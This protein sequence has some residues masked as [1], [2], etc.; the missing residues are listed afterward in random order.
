MTK[1]SGKRGFRRKR[2]KVEVPRMSTVRTLM[3]T[4]CS[5]TEKELTRVDKQAAPSNAPRPECMRVAKIIIVF[6]VERTVRQ[7]S[8][9]RNDGLRP[10]FSELFLQPR[11][12]LQLST[13]TRVPH[14]EGIRMCS[15]LPWFL[16]STRLQLG[17]RRGFGVFRDE[18]T[19]RCQ[20]QLSEAVFP[21]IIGSRVSMFSQFLTPQWSRCVQSP[22]PALALKPC[23]RCDSGFTGQLFFLDWAQACPSHRSAWQTVFS[24]LSPLQP[25]RKGL[26]KVAWHSP[27]LLCLHHD[28][29]LT[30][31]SK[32]GHLSSVLQ[33][34]LSLFPSLGT[35][36]PSVSQHLFAS[37][38][39]VQST[40]RATK[41]H[42]GRQDRLEVSFSI[43]VQ[44][45][46][47][48]PSHSAWQPMLPVL[49]TAAQPVS[50]GRHH[51]RHMSIFLPVCLSLASFLS[52][53][54]GF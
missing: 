46:F 45:F 39:L 41:V 32:G 3:P 40:A 52:L 1:M 25:S 5:K 18:S 50:E 54:L 26:G 33:V 48:V 31:F 53:L 42:P 17:L 38:P 49:S 4:L 6:C 16:T 21:P 34:C 22:V 27:S 35:V 11:A 7:S 19:A 2:G 13:L 44:L 51:E 47:F 29:G 12:Q 23:S 28:F 43:G 24:V 20:L 8:Q 14:L 37:A 36:K 9:R 15:F 30:H 10:R